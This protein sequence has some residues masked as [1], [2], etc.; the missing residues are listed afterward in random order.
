VRLFVDFHIH[1]W[2]SGEDPYQKA[3]LLCKEDEDEW[4]IRT[5]VGWNDYC[6]Y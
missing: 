1:V 6:L 4:L 2:G 5:L 3:G